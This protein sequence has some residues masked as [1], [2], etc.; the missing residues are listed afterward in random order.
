MGIWTGSG[1]SATERRMR[2]A[3]SA[4]GLFEVTTERD[5]PARGRSRTVR[6]EAIVSALRAGGQAP[7]RYIRIKGVR[8]EGDLDLAA[9]TLTSVIEFTSCHFDGAVNLRDS[10]LASLK[11]HGCSAATID[12]RNA[13]F[14]GS[15][16]IVDGSRCRTLQLGGARIGGSLVLEGS[17]FDDP[18]G[19]CIS[20]WG[21]QVGG[22]ML[23]GHGFTS[24]GE[25]NIGHADISGA[26]SFTGARLHHPDGWALNAQGA[27][28][29]YAL[30]LGSAIDDDSGFR[31][32]GAIRLVGAKIDGFV[33]CWDARLRCPG[34]YALQGLGLTVREDLLLNSGFSAEGTLHLDGARI[35]GYLSL[36]GAALHG[37]GKS[38]LL[39]R[40]MHVEGSVRCGEDFTAFGP[41]DMTGLSVS[42]VVDF[43]AADLRCCRSV[44]LS[45]VRAR[46]LRID[47]SSPPTALDL[48]HAEVDV[49][50]DDL[51]TWPKVI[52]LTDFTYGRLDPRCDAS[53]GDRIGWLRRSR[54]GHSPGAY[55]VLSAVY[56][57]AGRDRDSR[58]ISIAKFWSE[59]A[60]FGPPG[61][62]W[63]WLMYLT[64]GYGYRPWQ[65]VL[66]LAVLL[67]AGTTVFGMSY[68]DDITRVAGSAEFSPF[69]YTVDVLVPVI[70]LGQRTSWQPHNLA[71]YAM[72]FLTVT[73]WLLTTAVIA[74]VAR[75]LK[76]E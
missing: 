32:D 29:G 33:C 62:A 24:H 12:A 2:R 51:A 40:R 26:L 25:V 22:S 10:D 38:A 8:I 5:G 37:S 17:D 36:E 14:S 72:W 56:R 35:G 65:A 60:A 16:A 54:S 30:F 69:A 9:M 70:N 55:D 50:A 15:L 71:A 13:R 20:A 53:A 44:D 23:C 57:S 19:T 31:C 49:L 21:I 1:L 46:S 67:L 42:G 3:I 52:E 6:A 76:R 47:W 48:R 41:V 7:P 39:A 34:R 64:V 11:L 68:P 43:R 73:G 59:R 58:R 66:W 61:R 27:R 75:V 45:Y 74:G 18:A 4:H 28:I 63:N